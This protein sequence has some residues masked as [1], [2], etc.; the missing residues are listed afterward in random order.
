MEHFRGPRILFLEGGKDIISV[1]QDIISRGP[2]HN[3]RGPGYY[4]KGARCAVLFENGE[5]GVVLV[6][7][8]MYFV[9]SRFLCLC[10]A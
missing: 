10:L 8:V 6:M 7:V 3:F 4:F 2:G 1:G 5:H 9:E